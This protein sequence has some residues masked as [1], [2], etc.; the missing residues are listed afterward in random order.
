MEGVTFDE[1]ESERVLGGK[2]EG[3]GK[4]RSGVTLD[5]CGSYR[6]L[7]RKTKGRGEGQVGSGLSWMSGSRAELKARKRRVGERDRGVQLDE[8][9]G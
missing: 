1:C 3:R 2:M 9:G 4:V 7:G 8:N 5:E 6:V